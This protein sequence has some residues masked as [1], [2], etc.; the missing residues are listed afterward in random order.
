LIVKL[1]QPD[2]P[3]WLQS[4]AEDTHRKCVAER[5]DREESGEDQKIPEPPNSARQK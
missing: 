4:V 3:D 2:P 1:P 5:H